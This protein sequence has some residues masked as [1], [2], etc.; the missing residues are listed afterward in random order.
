MN[1]TERVKK[2]TLEVGADIAGVVLVEH[3]KEVTPT[4]QKPLKLLKR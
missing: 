1:L 2:F 4:E 3:L